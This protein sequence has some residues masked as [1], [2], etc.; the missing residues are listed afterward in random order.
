[1]SVSAE[2]VNG[3]AE[4]IEGFFD[5]RSPADAVKAVAKRVPGFRRSNIA[6][7][8]RKEKRTLRIEFLE[9]IKEFTAKK[10]SEY[11]NGDKEIP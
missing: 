11:I 3:I 10:L 5:V 1:M 7:G 2:I 9:S 8:R 4:A 6:A